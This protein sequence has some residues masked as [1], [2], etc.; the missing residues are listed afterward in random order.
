MQ[1]GFYFFSLPMS[2]PVQQLE[3]R[4]AEIAAE[5]SALGDFRR[6]PLPR[7]RCGNPNCHCHQPDEKGHGPNLRLTYKAN[8][9]TVTESFPTP[10][11]QRKAEREVAEFQKYRELS[12]TF[13]ATNEE[14][15]RARPVD[16]TLSAQKKTAETIQQEVGKEVAKLLAVAFGAWRR[17]GRIELEAVEMPVRDSMHH[18]GASAL[19]RLLS[20][21]VSHAAE[22]PCA[23]RQAARYHDTRPNQL[24]RAVG[25]VSIE[26]AYY[27][28][29]HLSSRTE[30]A[31]PDPGCGGNRIFAWR[32]AHDR[33][34]GQRVQF[35]AGG[36][37]K[38]TC[39]LA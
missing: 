29:S 31:G 30:P 14:V 28:C 7:G 18:A 17:T 24:L 1:A 23:C 6:V 5:I 10:A 32:A 34:R 35:P 20:M 11:A 2:E 36:A 4:R 27:I 38:W 25:P 33:C 22:T 26:R 39:W 13:V 37:S 15:C 19:S 12:P 21:P 8:G 3:K 9:K 16:D